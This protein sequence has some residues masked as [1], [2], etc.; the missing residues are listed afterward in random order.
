MDEVKR[1]SR[2]KQIKEVLAFHRKGE[3]AYAS[4]CKQCCADYEKTRWQQKTPKYTR[5]A[6]PKPIPP[7][8]DFLRVLHAI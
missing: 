7:R 8:R 5:P 2:C 3:F 6:V 4:W 1:C